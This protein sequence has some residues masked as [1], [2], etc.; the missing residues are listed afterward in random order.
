ME[1]RFNV[2]ITGK[3][4]QDAGQEVD[5]LQMIDKVSHIASMDIIS[6]EGAVIVTKAQPG[7]AR[8]IPDLMWRCGVCN[9]GFDKP[10]EARGCCDE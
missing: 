1:M 2:D 6:D 5:G 9:A 3:N 4:K 8:I 10:V 7:A